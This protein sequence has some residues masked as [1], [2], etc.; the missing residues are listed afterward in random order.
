MDGKAEVR[1]RQLASEA[2]GQEGVQAER[3]GPQ[4]DPGVRRRWH[5]RCQ[6][7]A[8]LVTGEQSATWPPREP[9]KGP[10]Q[11]SG[12]DTDPDPTGRGEPWPPGNL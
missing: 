3:K 7:K 4:A 6:P 1:R 9:A 10:S 11:G 2:E 5:C 12:N 8:Q